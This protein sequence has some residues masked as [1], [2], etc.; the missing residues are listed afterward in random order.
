MK[1]AEIT[2]ATLSALSQGQ[3]DYARIN[4]ANGDMVGHTGDLRSTIISLETLDLSLGRLLKG[5]E[6]LGGAAL[7]TADHGNADLMLDETTGQPHTAHT[8]TH[9]TEPSGLA[10]GVAC[11]IAA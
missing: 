6:S 8:T 10:A 9:T 7:I 3:F 11:T 5:I 2:D 1:A 4:Y